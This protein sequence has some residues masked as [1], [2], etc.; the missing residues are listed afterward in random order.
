MPPQS[1]S[2]ADVAAWLTTDF[3]GAFE[4]DVDPRNWAGDRGFYAIPMLTLS[5]C[6]AMAGL[7]NGKANGGT[8][9]TVAFLKTR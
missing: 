9:L 7:M 1:T 4:R 3:I 6:D 8:M 5:Y 2:C